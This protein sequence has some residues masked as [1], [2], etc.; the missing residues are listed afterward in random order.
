MTLYL[1]RRLDVPLWLSL[2][3]MTQEQEWKVSSAQSFAVDPW[4][5]ALKLLTSTETMAM[6]LSTTCILHGFLYGGE[7][8]LPSRRLS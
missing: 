1:L 3:R 5:L 2:L 6:E 8:K 7:Y 4:V